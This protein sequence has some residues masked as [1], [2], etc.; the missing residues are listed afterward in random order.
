MNGDHD[1]TVVGGYSAADWSTGDRPTTITVPG[2]SPLT[3]SQSLRLQDVTVRGTLAVDGPDASLYLERTRHEHN[4]DGE[5]SRE[6]AAVVSV[7]SGRIETREVLVSGG[8]FDVGPNGEA[9]LTN[10]ALDYLRVRGGNATVRESIITNVHLAA[11]AEVT[12]RESRLGGDSGDGGENTARIA[13]RTDAPV[14]VASGTLSLESSTVESATDVRDA[15]ALRMDAGRIALTNTSVTARGTRSAVALR[16]SGGVLAVEESELRA[17]G[18]DFAYAV[19]LRDTAAT[20]SDALLAAGSDT[21]ATTVVTSD[22]VIHLTDAV[23]VAS[24]YATIADAS[25]QSGASSLT[26]R[27]SAAHQS[28]PVLSAIDARGGLGELRVS[29]TVI[30][31]AEA[32]TPAPGVPVPAIRIGAELVTAVDQTVF[33]GWS[34]AVEAGGRRGEWLQ[35]GGLRSA[36]AVGDGNRA[37]PAAVYPGATA[38]NW[39]ERSPRAIATR[40]RELRSL[41]E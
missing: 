38:L 25:E 2:T 30:L 8:A 16:A 27:S 35:A 39:E 13:L 21:E 26:A 28:H 41:V 9:H 10:A 4:G 20:V 12:V 37:L 36:L 22:A 23:L 14:Y 5:R 6:V 3:I 7:V 15:L 1:W 24:H 40:R 29:G 32:G 31:G 19:V 11:A 33:A 34:H 18:G 17:V